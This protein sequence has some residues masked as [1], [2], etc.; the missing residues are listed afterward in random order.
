MF[1]TIGGDVV[2]ELAPVL[3]AVLLS[4]GLLL[5]MELSVAEAWVLSEEDW[6]P[7]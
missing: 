2:V 4:A 5:E 7:D 6:D 1:V 3:V